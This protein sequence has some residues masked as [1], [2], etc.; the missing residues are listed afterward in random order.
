[1]TITGA[2]AERVYRW[3]PFLIRAGMGL[4][5]GFDL[6]QKFGRNQSI[7]LATP[8]DVWLGGGD[9]PFSLAAETLSVVS[10]SDQDSAGGTGCA[11]LVIFGLDGDYQPLTKIVALT[12]MTPVIISTA[13]FLR[14]PRAICLAPGST[15]TLDRNDGVITATQTSSGDV[16][17]QI[18]AGRGQ[19]EQA[20]YTVQADCSLMLTRMYGAIGRMVAT[21]ALFE[22]EARPI[23]ECWQIKHPI[24]ANST[25]T[26]FVSVD[27]DVPLT[28]PAKTD[29][30]VRAT[31]GANGANVSGGFDGVL[32]E[33][34]RF[35]VGD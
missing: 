11:T 7:D 31:V 22:L 25:G 18:G 14:T 16:V 12:G 15:S 13:A 1:M 5:P 17:I 28:F 23:G 8:E 30:R 9:Y 34:S 10:T 20:I 4:A 3:T 19:T 21:Q 27:F 33:P 29:L 35:I 32:F 24:D 6:L 26:T 2:A